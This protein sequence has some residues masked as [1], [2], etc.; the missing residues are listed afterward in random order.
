[1]PRKLL[2]QLLAC[3]LAVT[4]WG[5]GIPLVHAASTMRDE[6]VTGGFT[7]SQLLAPTYAIDQAALAIDTS[8]WTEKWLLARHRF[9]P[10]VL[11][12]AAAVDSNATADAAQPANDTPEPATNP[13]A[14]PAP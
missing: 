9:A 5:A 4:S 6:G 2:L 14:N 7:A 12:G 8:Y 1:M 13:A 3:M 10:S 11:A